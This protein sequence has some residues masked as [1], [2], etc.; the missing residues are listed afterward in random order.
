M[1]PLR[2][3]SD[4]LKV[5]RQKMESYPCIAKATQ[6]VLSSPVISYLCNRT[7]SSMAD[8]KTKKRSSL[9]CENDTL[10]FIVPKQSFK[11]PVWFPKP[12]NRNHI[13]AKCFMVKCSWFLYIWEKK[14]LEFEENLQNNV[15]V[16]EY[17]S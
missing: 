4:V 9:A 8:I 10:R 5:R 2:I 17:K 16:K 13:D 1:E 11:I 7:F 12:N 15:K 14:N 6:N 3:D